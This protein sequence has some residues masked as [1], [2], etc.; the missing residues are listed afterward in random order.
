[1]QVLLEVS[2]RM[3]KVLL[4]K[5]SNRDFEE[6]KKFD[7]FQKLLDFMRERHS[8]WIVDFRQSAIKDYSLDE[9]SFAVME[10]DDYV[11]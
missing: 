3:I 11:E 9:C 5:A 7:S 6:V 2:A 10:Y 8:K 1:M 4:S